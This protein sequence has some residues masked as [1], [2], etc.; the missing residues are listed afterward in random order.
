MK[1]ESLVCK[2][3]DELNDYFV[4][5]SCTRTSEPNA[6][7]LNKS[8]HNHSDFISTKLYIHIVLYILIFN[9]VLVHYAFSSTRT[10]TYLCTYTYTTCEQKRAVAHLLLRRRRVQLLVVRPVAL[11]L[12][13][14]TSIAA[15]LAGAE[16]RLRRGRAQRRRRGGRPGR[17]GRR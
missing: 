3:I 14:R 12:V 4:L 8:T 13:E 17:R 9:S 5:C 1:L 16:A 6:T 10:H 7:Q 2:L 15:V 11:R